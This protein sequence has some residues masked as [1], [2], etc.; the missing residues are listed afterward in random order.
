M[1]R[2]GKK[3]KK[4]DSENVAIGGGENNVLQLLV[5]S[6]HVASAILRS[7]STSEETSIVVTRYI[8]LATSKC[9]ARGIVPSE[10][11]DATRP[12]DSP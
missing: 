2:R 7:M 12:P 11:D 5:Y 1:G 4:E 10:A 9:Q 3:K 8:Y 6:R